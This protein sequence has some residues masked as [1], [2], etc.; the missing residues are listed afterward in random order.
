MLILWRVKPR[1]IS[2]NWRLLALAVITPLVAGSCR[3]MLVGVRV[4]MVS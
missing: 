3:K 4:G 1:I 2:D